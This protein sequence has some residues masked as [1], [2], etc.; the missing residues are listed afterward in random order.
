MPNE[1][2]GAP[3]GRGELAVRSAKI[4]I[5]RDHFIE[6]LDCLVILTVIAVGLS[7]LRGYDRSE[8]QADGPDC[9]PQSRP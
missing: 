9:L 6:E 7:L 8:G 1:I 2:M 3:I 5:V 4:R